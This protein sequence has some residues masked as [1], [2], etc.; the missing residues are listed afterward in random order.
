MKKPNIN[1]QDEFLINILTTASDVLKTKEAFNPITKDYFNRNDEAL[2]IAGAEI[3][4]SLSGRYENQTLYT[5]NEIGEY[6]LCLANNTIDSTL[7]ELK[8]TIAKTWKTS[9]SKP[10]LKKDYI[11]QPN[12]YYTI[13][14]YFTSAEEILECNDY[15]IACENLEQAMIHL[16]K[17]T[18]E[19]NAKA[20]KD[21]TNLVARYKED[22]DSWLGIYKKGLDI[23]YVALAERKAEKAIDTLANE[24]EEIKKLLKENTEFLYAS[25]RGVYD[26]FKSFSLEPVNNI[27][28]Y[29]GLRIVEGIHICHLP[30][31]IER[32]EDGNITSRISGARRYLNVDDY[33]KDLEKNIDEAKVFIETTYHKKDGSLKKLG[34]GKKYQE[35]RQKT[36]RLESLK[37]DLAFVIR[38]EKGITKYLGLWKKSS[39]LM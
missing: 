28:M 24:N 35:H 5:N 38:N 34:Y 20:I 30:D 3:A 22:V 27:A 25:A 2:E 26:L 33:I 29:K 11:I 21:L 23:D 32:D 19:N 13:A 36:N 7:T 15:L 16:E 12:A 4:E 9:W 6:A 18:Q 31:I 37:V 8:K 1:K 39:D 14:C 10:S 17:F